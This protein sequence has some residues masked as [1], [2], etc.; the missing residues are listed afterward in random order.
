M[1]C[2]VRMVIVNNYYIWQD[3]S[4]GSY[5]NSSSDDSLSRLTIIFN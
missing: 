4:D 2:V 1:C 3:L 5:V